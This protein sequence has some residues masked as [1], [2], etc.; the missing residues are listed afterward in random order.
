MGE[1]FH[2]W[3]WLNFVSEIS[4]FLKIFQ[5][6]NFKNLQHTYKILT[7]QVLM[8]IILN[9]YAHSEQTY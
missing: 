9:V 5:I 4:K 7:I 3:S 2:C 1:I 8:I 6:L